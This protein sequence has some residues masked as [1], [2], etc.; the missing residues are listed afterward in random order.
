MLFIFERIMVSV[1]AIVIVA[2]IDI[3][4]PLNFIMHFS[5]KRTNGFGR[6]VCVIVAFRI[7]HI[8][9]CIL[10]THKPYGALTQGCVKTSNSVPYSTSGSI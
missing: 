5:Q 2:Q 1:A 4:P 10:I 6:P 3:A 7:S 9:S 8:Y